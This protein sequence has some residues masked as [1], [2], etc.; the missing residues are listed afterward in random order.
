M[1]GF[2][3]IAAVSTPYGKGGVAVIRVSG[4]KAIEISEKVF[5]AKNGKK[6]SDMPSRTMCYG[7]IW[8]TY[9]NGEKICI[10]DG[11]AAVFRAPAS[12]TG[13]ETVEI[14][15]HGGILVTQNVFSA[16]I[17]AGARAARAGEFTRRA[18][19]NGK[20]KLTQAEAL[21]HL[22][23]AENENQLLLSRGGMRGILSEKTEGIYN[24]LVNVMGSVYAKI[25][26]PDEDLS[27][28]GRDEIK[29]ELFAI[30][31]EI[32]ALAA[33]YK[34]GRAVSQGIPTAICGHT[35]VG[36]SSVYNRIVGYDAAIVTD[37][38]G[39]TRDV[40]REKVSFGGVTL[41]ISDTAGIRET[42]D[43]VENIGIK[44]A[45]DE[46]DDCELILAVFDRNKKIDDAD[47][48]FYKG[49]LDSGKEIIALFNKSDVTG[50]SDTEIDDGG[51]FKR[52]IFIS[53][54]TGEGFD[55]LAKAVGELYIDGGISLY[56]DAVV[57]DGRQYSAL[58]SCV[59]E[60]LRASDALDS[61][62]PLDL[63]SVD[64]EEAMSSLA[65]LDGR[66]IG[67]DVVA[68][69]FSRFCVGK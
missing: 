42:D 51:I 61:G 47:K 49:L 18:F 33:T 15:C 20:I 39:T 6:L 14:N 4:E 3:T 5:F 30:R 53:A 45:I 27:D 8:R 1:M 11:M 35:N 21:G 13:E 26:F 17:E 43:I 10:D 64:I 37:I 12:F 2:D 34:T 40:L 7:E 60:I 65:E 44:R 68:N 38:E 9:K 56:T 24:R 63:C 29:K 50:N 66:E 32:E 59:E 41:R 19:V 16:L 31:E 36:K 28:L 58:L 46:I 22:L 25:D 48:E 55:T 62:L 52:K 54:K 23:E 67:E 57:S 69:I